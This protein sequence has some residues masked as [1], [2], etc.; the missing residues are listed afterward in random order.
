MPDPR[1]WAK[2]QGG[3][4]IKG[5]TNATQPEGRSLKKTEKRV[6]ENHLGGVYVTAM[7]DT[8]TKKT[9]QRLTIREVGVGGLTPSKRPWKIEEM[10][11]GWGGGRSEKGKNNSGGRTAQQRMERSWE[12]AH[13]VTGGDDLGPDL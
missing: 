5:K 1:A 6:I 8:A 11:E 13:M 4:G 9:T 3:P 7:R 12:G 2:S 10:C